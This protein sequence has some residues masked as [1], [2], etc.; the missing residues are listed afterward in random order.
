MDIEVLQRA[1]QREKARRIKA[2]QLLETKSRDL[3]LSYEDLSQSHKDLLRINEMLELKQ[4]QLLD[5]NN[6]HNTVT[7]DLKLAANL[8]FQ[9]LPN[10]IRFDNVEATG[11]SKPAMFVA[12]DIYDY[13]K[14]SDSVLAF[15]MA[16]VTGHG[17][18]A[19]MVSYAIHKQMN[20]KDAGICASN[21][22]I[23]STMEDAVMSTVSDLNMEYALLE[24]DSHY[25]TLVYGLL[26]IETG[27]VCLCQAGHPAPIHYS[28]SNRSIQTIGNGGFPVGMFADLSY[29]TNNFILGLGDSLYVYSDGITECFSREGELFGEARLY[30]SI[31]NTGETSLDTTLKGIEDNI[32]IWNDSDVFADDVSILALKRH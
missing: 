31:L 25:F 30:D 8:Q 14:L 19:A 28:Q 24:G 5:L 32:I 1:Y 2:E 17:P 9:I 7:N 21:F 4:K 27:E 3:F 26:N 18:A 20:P 29:T 23:H 16:D 22:R 15:Y 10:A 11:L 12:G 6:A 13:Y